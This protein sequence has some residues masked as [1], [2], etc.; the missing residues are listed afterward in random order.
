MCDCQ[1]SAIAQ[2]ELL[3]EAKGAVRTLVRQVPFAQHGGSDNFLLD[4]T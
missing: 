3:A 4:W 1:S 2:E